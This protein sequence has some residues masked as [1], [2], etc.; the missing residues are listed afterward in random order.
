MCG[1]G[2]TSRFGALGRGAADVCARGLLTAL[3]DWGGDEACS[4]VNGG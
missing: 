4:Y 3:W 2:T 1:A